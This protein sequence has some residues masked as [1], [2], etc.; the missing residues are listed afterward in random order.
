MGRLVYL[1]AGLARSPAIVK[2]MVDKVNPA[3]YDERLSPDRFSLR[4]VVAHLADLEPVILSRYELALRS[5]GAEIENWDQ[6]KEAVE[7][8]YASW[9][10]QH[11]LAKYADARAK[12]MAK[13][14]SLSEDQLHL[15]LRHPILGEIT[16][17]DLTVFVLGH[18]TY[19]F[20]QIS[21]YL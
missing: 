11:S 7:K 12:T 21:E 18:D 15:T 3:R 8:D 5:P 9:D 17:F 10:V 14:K 4:E 6:D 20:D 1:E 16:L 2:R 13:F 19:H